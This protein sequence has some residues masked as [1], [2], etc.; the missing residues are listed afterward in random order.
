[1]MEKIGLRMINGREPSFNEDKEKSEQRK[2]NH[3]REEGEDTVEK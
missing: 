3:C 2:G 1:M